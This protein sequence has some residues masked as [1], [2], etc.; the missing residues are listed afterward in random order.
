[1]SKKKTDSLDVVEQTHPLYATDRDMVDSILGHKG[2]PGP[3]QITN[4]A[5]L[6]MRYMD[7][8]GAYDI[9]DD[10]EK[11]IKFW[12]WD[13]EKLNTESRKIWASGWRPGMDSTPEGVGSGADA[14]DKD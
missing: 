5:R 14:E 1:M 2:E 8:P 6:F 12:G 3:E 10:L 7:F 13:H 4:A 11:A 9:K